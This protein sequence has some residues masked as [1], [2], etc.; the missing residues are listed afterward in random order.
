MC[1]SIS[2][3]MQWPS[4][5]Y[6][7]NPIEHLMLMHPLISFSYLNSAYHTTVFLLRINCTMNYFI[8]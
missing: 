5:I 4:S 8:I 2:T 3:F 1:D 6:Y 7:V